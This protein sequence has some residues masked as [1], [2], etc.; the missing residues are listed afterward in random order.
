L[1][2]IAAFLAALALS[3]PSIPFAVS[4]TDAAEETAYVSDGDLSDNGTAVIAV[5]CVCVAVAAAATVIV[6]QTV[7]KKKK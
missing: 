2:K 1:R 5:V 7:Q 4:G 3:I 6:V